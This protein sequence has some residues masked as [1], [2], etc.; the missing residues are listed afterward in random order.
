MSSKEQTVLYYL[1]FYGESEKIE[2]TQEMFDNFLDAAYPLPDD[3][4]DAYNSEQDG[5]ETLGTLTVS[6]VEEEA[7][8]IHNG[9]AI[10][11]DE[12]GP[13][14]SLALHKILEHALEVH[15]I[16]NQ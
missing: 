14:V 11:E 2:F 8:F 7:T 1:Q 10:P 4:L 3:Y 9:T 15:N 13:L 12:V 6:T 16:R 5:E